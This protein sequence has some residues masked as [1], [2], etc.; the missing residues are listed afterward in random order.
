MEYNVIAVAKPQDYHVALDLLTQ[1]YQAA[2][3]TL[4]YEH[5][6]MEDYLLRV[7]ELKAEYEQ[8]RALEMKVVGEQ[9]EADTGLA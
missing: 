1:E 7:Q 3:R 9:R 2:L 4:I 8:Q 6:P 5:L